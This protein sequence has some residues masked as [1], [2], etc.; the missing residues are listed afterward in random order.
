M[1]NMYLNFT[2]SLG[3]REFYLPSFTNEGSV[4]V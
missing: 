4:D 1:T 2:T 3:E